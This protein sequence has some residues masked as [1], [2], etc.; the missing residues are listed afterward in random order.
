[1]KAMLL[2][3]GVG[4]RLD[5]LTSQIPKPLVPI[6]NIP[7]MQHILALLVRHGVNEVSANLH[8]LP[9]KLIEHFNKTSELGVRL[10]F[11][12][13]EKLTGD[14]GGV[15]A[16]RDFFDQGT[17]LV[18]MGDLLTDADLTAV[19]KE[20]K[21]K[22][23]LATIA[24][25]RVD[26]VSH[27][28]VALMNQ[29]GFITGFQEKPA[30]DQ[31]LSNLVSTGIYVFEPAIFEHIPKE[32][33]YG[34]GRQLFPKLVKLGFPILGVEITS[35]WSDV[36]T[37]NQ[38]RQSNF[39]ALDQYVNLDLPGDVIRMPEYTAWIGSNSL[40]EK[41]C[42]IEGSLMIGK[43][44][45]IKTRAII[46]GHVIIGDNCSIDENAEI[47]DSVIWSNSRIES[48]TSVCNSIIGLNCSVTTGTKHF[49]AVSVS[50]SPNEISVLK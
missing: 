15:R 37:I 50:S 7:V 20:H 45:R 41:G 34:F 35:Y 10:H 44:S 49:S 21:R 11:K 14:A 16:C 17:F 42:R 23:A 48:N 9:E 18:V 22:K 31:A 24:L 40:I 46:K 25:K 43:N 33:E 30:P 28:G 29:E 8:Y 47:I 26:D 5:P 2:A 4:S 12:H 39:D 38:Y 13:E 32:G 27:F 3:A 36:G 6:A 1:M 19:V